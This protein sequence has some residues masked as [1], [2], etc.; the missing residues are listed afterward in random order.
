MALTTFAFTY[1]YYLD[2]KHTKP[3]AK[4]KHL[5]QHLIILL[6]IVAIQIT[7]G[8][9]VAGLHAGHAA[10]TWPSINGEWIPESLPFAF[11]KDGIISLVENPLSLQFIH[12]SLAYA[13]ALYL[14]FILLKY[15]KLESSSAYLIPIL[16]AVMIQIALG[17]FTLFSKINITLAVLHQAGAFLMLLC[18]IRALHYYLSTSKTNFKIKI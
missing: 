4:H 17:V 3:R 10:Y 13:I 7:F 14:G 5:S 6:I 12:R 11:Q 8:A 18:I 1:W 15:A 9:F 16:Y 2:I